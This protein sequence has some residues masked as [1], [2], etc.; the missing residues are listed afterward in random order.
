MRKH[1]PDAV[2]SKHIK[3][4]KT[5]HQ[6]VMQKTKKKKPAPYMMHDKY[7]QMAKKEGYRARSV[8]KLKEIQETF[9]LIEEN[10]DICDI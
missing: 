4:Q 6:S 1:K 5:G 9:E 3:K 8:Y 2:K 7:F 10:M